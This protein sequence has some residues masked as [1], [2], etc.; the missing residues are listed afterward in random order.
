MCLYAVAATC[1]VSGI[2][3][4]VYVFSKRTYLRTCEGMYVFMFLAR[5]HTSLTHTDTHTYTLC[6]TLTLTNTLGSAHIQAHTHRMSVWCATCPW[7]P[8]KHTHALTHIHT[9]TYS[10]S[11]S[12]S[13]SHAH[14]QA[15]HV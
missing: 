4:C 12:L 15:A 8:Q 1:H 13:L 3:M 2:F 5:K 7:D 10:L 9:Q 6:H 11:V 14:T